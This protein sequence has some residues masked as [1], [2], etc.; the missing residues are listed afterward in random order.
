MK[1]NTLY[2]IIFLTI[3]LF[4][5]NINSNGQTTLSFTYNGSKAAVSNPT[6][7]LTDVTDPTLSTVLGSPVSQTLNVSGVNL[8]VDL[9]LS[10]TGTDAGL[11]SL[12]QYTVT[13]TGGNI[14]NT[15]VTITYTP[16]LVGTNTATLMMTSTGAM[17]V[18]RTLNGISSIA[19]GLY[20]TNKSLFVTVENGNILFD[21]NAGENVEI[22]NSVGQKL[23]QKQTVEGMNTIPVSTRGV[24]L[25]K[26]GNR[27]SKVIL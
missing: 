3:I 4:V 5:I 20:T 1:E 12:S 13:Q 19:T 16:T 25:V 17:P 26:V 10:I 24:L 7:T 14:P 23:V 6:I 9:G 11:F 2:K 27:V 22:F 18:I 21:A 15:L 8:S